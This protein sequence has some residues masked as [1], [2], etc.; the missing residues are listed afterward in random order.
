[1]IP[2]AFGRFRNGDWVLRTVCDTCNHYFGSELDEVLARGTYEGMLRYTRGQSAASGIRGKA[3]GERVR[4]KAKT[5]SWAGMHLEHR[6]SADGK[7]VCVVPVRQLGFCKTSDGEYRYFREA[8]IPSRA[9][10]AELLGPGHVFVRAMNVTEEELSGLL[11]KHGFSPQERPTLVADVETEGAIIG[12]A[13]V[14]TADRVVFRAMTK[15]AF[16]YLAAIHPEIAPLPQFD[17]ARAFVR[18]DRGESHHLISARTTAAIANDPPGKRFSGH[19]LALRA[20]RQT[21]LLACDVSLY[22]GIVYG[23]ALAGVPFFITVPLESLERGHFFDP[24][25]QTVTQ[26]V[27]GPDLLRRLFVQ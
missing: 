1:M 4:T 3:I 12:V 5:G 27:R 9:E 22:N 7:G 16:N 6:P 10:V 14:L 2:Q 25:H 20:N 15:I 24:H 26:L 23:V 11:V 13:H 17:A 8:E 21:G 18:F 19:I